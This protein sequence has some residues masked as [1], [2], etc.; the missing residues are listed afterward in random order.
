MIEKY[1]ITP[2][3]FKGEPQYIKSYTK[4]AY[5]HTC[6]KCPERLYLLT[7]G[8]PFSKRRVM[9]LINDE[10]KKLTNLSRIGF[11]KEKIIEV[12]KM[13]VLYNK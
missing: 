11:A 7:G 4:Y 13:G 8:L 1:D 12:V 5:N 3:I 9:N 6:R 2:I 10:S